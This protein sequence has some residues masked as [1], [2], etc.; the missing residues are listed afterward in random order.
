MTDPRYDPEALAELMRDHRF[1]ASAASAAIVIDQPSPP[2]PY[3]LDHPEEL[4]A[5]GFVKVA[6][7]C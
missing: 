1:I 6:E 5:L 7:L 3:E 2:M 4:L